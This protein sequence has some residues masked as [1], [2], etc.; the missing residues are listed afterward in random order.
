MC[1]HT[2]VNWWCNKSS[3][4]IGCT[5]I[6]ALN[7]TWSN[8]LAHC[9]QPLP[10]FLVCR[11]TADPRI[12]NDVN[13]IEQPFWIAK[14]R[15]VRELW[16]D[17]DQFNLMPCCLCCVSTGTSWETKEEYHYHQEYGKRR[18]YTTLSIACRIWSN[19][20]CCCAT[21]LSLVQ[22]SKCP[23][24]ELECWEFTKFSAFFPCWTHKVCRPYSTPRWGSL[25]ALYSAEL[26]KA[27]QW[28]SQHLSSQAIS[29][30]SVQ[31]IGKRL[32]WSCV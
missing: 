1:A 11:K 22:E 7:G 16:S 30:F 23:T 10:V 18:E 6:L 21:I 31:I 8:H 25:T 13:M 17:G 5:R 14:H 12:W 32:C 29:F 20:L 3:H 26:N 28:W 15:T 24:W 4:L 19:W 2:H 27:T 9:T